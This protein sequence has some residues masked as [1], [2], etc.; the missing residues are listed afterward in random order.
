MAFKSIS[1]QVDFPAL[2]KRDI[3]MVVR[4]RMMKM[5]CQA[6][7]SKT[8]FSFLDGPITTNNPW[9]ITPHKTGHYKDLI[10]I[11]YNERGRRPVSKWF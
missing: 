4:K 5:F 7:K 8:K 1:S 10:T 3:E 6:L 9:A 11:S 2:E